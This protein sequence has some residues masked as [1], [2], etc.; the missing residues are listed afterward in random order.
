MGGGGFQGLDICE[1]I[2]FHSI[3]FSKKVE[4]INLEISHKGKRH[5]FSYGFLQNL[6]DYFL[7]LRFFS[8]SNF[9]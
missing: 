1:I 2:Q 3:S 8:M 6:F 7:R 5:I 4:K 9:L